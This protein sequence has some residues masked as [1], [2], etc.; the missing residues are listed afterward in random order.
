MDHSAGSQR[1]HRFS[2][3]PSCTRRLCQS[4]WIHRNSRLMRRWPQR[5]Q[6]THQGTQE[7]TASLIATGCGH[8]GLNHVESCWSSS[9][10]HVLY[11]VVNHCCRVEFH[12]SDIGKVPFLPSSIFWMLGSALGLGYIPA[13]PRGG[14][15]GD[16]GWVVGYHRNYWG[17]YGLLTCFHRDKY[18]I[19]FDVWINN[20]G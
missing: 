17:F 12:L 20:Y 15:G 10:I 7:D 3:F 18:R 8:Y 6:G 4:S 11:R 19:T 14:F 13:H 16:D 5:D 9:F 2:G 1:W